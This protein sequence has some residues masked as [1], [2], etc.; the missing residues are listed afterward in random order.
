M[1]RFEAVE[2]T[3]DAVNGI[4]HEVF[5]LKK[6]PRPCRQP[7]ARPAPQRRQAACEQHIDSASVAL[8]CSLEQIGGGFER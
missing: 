6:I 7:P 2:I 4:L 3:Q 5:G 1:A 8:P